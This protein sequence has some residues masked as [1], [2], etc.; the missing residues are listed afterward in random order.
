MKRIPFIAGNWKMYKTGPEAVKTAK[1]LAGLCS[2]L[3][4]VEVMVAPTFLSLPLVAA[5]LQG[6]RIKTGA[7]NLHFEKEGAFTGEVSGHMIKAAGADYVIIGHSERRQYFG[8]TDD[9]V[10]KKNKGSH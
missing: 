9:L 2:G 1:H 6:T 7:Q 5:S 4:D 3:K 10:K 8:E